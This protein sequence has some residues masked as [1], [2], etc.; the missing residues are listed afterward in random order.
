MIVG[1][2]EKPIFPR[3]AAQGKFAACFILAGF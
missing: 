2:V 3:M 1:V